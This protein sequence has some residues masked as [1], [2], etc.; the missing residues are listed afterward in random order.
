[1]EHIETGITRMR[2]Q[3]NELNLPEPE[4]IN[5]GYFK[6][7]LRGSNGKLI[8]PKNIGEHVNFNG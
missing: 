7:I 5:D 6:V 4:F 8:L 2:R 1:M 3:M